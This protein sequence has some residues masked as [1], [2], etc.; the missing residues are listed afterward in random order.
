ME[1]RVFVTGT[2][3]DAGK[4]VV[5]GV[6]AAAW[7]AHYWKP[8]QSGE[9]TDSQTMRGWI[10]PERVLPERHVLRDPLSPNQA[11]ERMGC[12]I[13]LADFSLPD[14]VG[15]LVVEGAGGLLVPL[16]QQ[17]MIID[18]IARLGLPVVLVCRTGLGTLNHTLL[19]LEALHHRGLPVAG[20]VFSGPAHPDNERDIRHFGGVPIWG[21][22]PRMHP[23]DAASFPQIYRE[24]L[25]GAPG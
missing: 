22:V 14:V 15:P 16:N 4:T 25:T 19:S 23:L 12:Q 2:D 3:T 10:P 24:Q 20:I 17:H 5:S 11:A 8:I 1:K 6:L 9:P 13:E 7:Q 21:R 18:L